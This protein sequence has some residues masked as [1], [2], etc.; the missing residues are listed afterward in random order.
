MGCLGMSLDDFYQCTPSEFYAVWEAWSENRSQTEH[1]MWERARMLALCTLQ[2]YMNKKLR[3]QDVMQFPW[4]KENEKMGKSK[5]GE[6][7]TPSEI[8]REEFM[9]RYRKARERRGM[10]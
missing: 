7:E 9:E 10:S 1:G 4:D 2:P 8:S 3:P 6:P 5:D